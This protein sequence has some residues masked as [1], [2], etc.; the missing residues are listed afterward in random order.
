MHHLDRTRY[1]QRC[2]AGWAHAGSG[3]NAEQGTEPF[4]LAG[5]DMVHDGLDRV[6]WIGQALFQPLFD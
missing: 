3:G 6:D 2:R 5:Q 4:P 1:I